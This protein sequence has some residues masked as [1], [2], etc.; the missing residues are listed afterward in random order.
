MQARL[1]HLKP[2]SLSRDAHAG[3]A[4]GRAIGEVSTLEAFRESVGPD[5]FYGER[6][7]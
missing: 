4:D 3:P 2:G 1:L 7:L 5:A 6:E